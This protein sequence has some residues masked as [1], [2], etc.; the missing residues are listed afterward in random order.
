MNALLPPRGVHCAPA[1][2][3]VL[4]HPFDPATRED[5]TGQGVCRLLQ[6]EQIDLTGPEQASFRHTAQRVLT[7]AGAELVSHFA[8]EFDP[9][10][11]R[12]EVHFLRVWRGGDCIEHAR[13]EALQTFRRET[14]LGRLI[15]NGRLTASVVIPDVRVDDVVEFG[16]TIYGANPVLK[17]KFQV[18]LGFDTFNPWNEI[19]VRLRRPLGR[20]VAV[21]EVNGAP[22]VERRE[23][24]G[25][26]ESS[27][28]VAGLKKRDPL[29]LAPPWLIPIPAVQLTEYE[30]WGE[31]ARLF[32]PLYEG[33]E[34]PEDLAQEIDGIAT[35]HESPAQRAVEWLRF[36]QRNLRYFALALGEGGLVPR[37][38]DQI[39]SARFGDCKD[40]ARLYVAGARRLGLDACAA[41]VATNFGL[42]LKDF[43]PGSH[44]F[45]HC[46]VRLKLDGKV[47]WLDPTLSGQAG[48]LDRLFQPYA[49]GAL[50]LTAETNELQEMGPY[51]P[52]HCL[53][54]EDELRLASRRSAPAE[55]TRRIDHASWIANSLRERF[56]NEGSTAYANEMLKEVRTIWPQVREIRSMTIEENLDENRL[57]TTFAYA[58]PEAWKAGEKAKRIFFEISDQV[59]PQELAHFDPEGRV[60][61]VYLARPRRVTRHVTVDL[62]RGWWGVGLKDR[63][64]A[65]GL[66]F[67]RTVS[68]TRRRVVHKKEFVVEAWSLPA[69]DAFVYSDIVK[70]L[71]ENNFMVHAREQ[72]G[73]IFP[74]YFPGWMKRVA[75]RIALF[76]AFLCAIFLFAR[77]QLP[78]SYQ[79]PLPYPKM[80]TGKA[81]S[82]A[83]DVRPS[84]PPRG[85]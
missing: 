68:Y 22:P 28:R 46:I 52:I 66:W 83:F 17:D 58:I 78:L 30:S 19:C 14:D 5:A 57:T 2:D 11:H 25:V 21:R 51:E 62:P 41:L 32:A 80:E 29:S 43:L 12:L 82:D 40:A 69:G 48:D 81:G 20:A 73:R 23:K 75:I 39:W 77:A 61:P 55:L 85:G 56:A 74:P 72:F 6:D 24:D 76:I 38:L 47:Y 13:P 27:W 65:R 71:R 1:P 79:V 67:A 36:V 63:R 31:I 53:H 42:A 64:E 4:E 35:R 49:G 15:L 34:I 37:A 84:R 3:W 60:D 18:W 8:V 54:Y 16:F 10:H 59:F 33:G 44:F 50:T 45:D 7:R 70:L 9:G 26:E